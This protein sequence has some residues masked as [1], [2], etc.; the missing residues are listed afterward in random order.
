MVCWDR[1]DAFVLTATSDRSVRVWDARGKHVRALRGHRDE[2]YVLEAHPFLPGVVLSAGHDGQLF[3][4]DARA[5]EVRP[6]VRFWAWWDILRVTGEVRLL[7]V[8]PTRL[9]PR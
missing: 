6:L 2:A 3:V 1:S 9:R 7:D 5:G 4:W 8:S